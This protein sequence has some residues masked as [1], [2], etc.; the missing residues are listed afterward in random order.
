MND[1]QLA[2]KEAVLDLAVMSKA[3]GTLKAL[4]QHLATDRVLVEGS[5]H[6]SGAT[7]AR[8]GDTVLRV[9]SEVEKSPVVFNWAQNVVRY[10]PDRVS[11]NIAS[12]TLGE[13]L[14]CQ[15]ELE[16]NGPGEAWVQVTEWITLMRQE[17]EPQPLQI[18]IVNAK[19]VFSPA[20]I[21]SV[22]RDDSGKLSGAT[23][24][25]IA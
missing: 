14:D 25:P 10:T 18:E 6:R 3:A 4:M 16:K 12:A 13:L 21:L 20:K 5:T 15:R 19:E 8:V 17:G 11:V 2:T 7:F 1:S 24:E 23:I 22:K 9:S